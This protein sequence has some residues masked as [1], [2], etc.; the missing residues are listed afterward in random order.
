[1][2][3]IISPAKSM[4][5]DSEAPVN[6]SSNLN[7]ATKTSSLINRLQSLSA[8]QLA[9]MMSV[10]KKIADLNHERFRT[11]KTLPEKSAIFAYTGDVYRNMETQ[12]LSPEM[13]GFGQ[14][15]L[16]IVSALY[17][18]LRPLDK[19]K[20]YR[21]EMITRLPGIAPKGLAT[22]WKKQVTEQLNTELANHQNKFLINIAS[23]E[24]A[25]VID[26]TNLNAQM[27]NIHFR[28]IR[29][30]AVKNIA[31]NSKRARGM[32][33][34]YIIRNGLDSPED[35]KLFNKGGYSLN[36]IMSDDNNF[37]FVRPTLPNQ[38]L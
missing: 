19:I 16:R 26:E 17:G 29:D 24:Y 15:H 25:A 23:N 32:L 10:S 3:S 35:I 6:E 28:E 31:L 8:H 5:F 9:K 7:F 21:L 30:G 33:A 14:N 13:L 12:T 37:F 36:Q 18:L 27:I 1:M 22:F 2:I 11:Y 20:A 38:V 34:D 4:D